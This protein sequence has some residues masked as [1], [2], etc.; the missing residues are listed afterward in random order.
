M[1]L[2]R[3]DEDGAKQFV[4]PDTDLFSDLLYESTM[5]RMEKTGEY[6]S[7]QIDS[8][9]RFQVVPDKTYL[10]RIRSE[11]KKFARIYSYPDDSGLIQEIR[12]YTMPFVLFAAPE[13]HEFV[14]NNGMGEISRNG[15][16]MLDMT[17]NN[18]AKRTTNQLLRQRANSVRFEREKVE[19][20][21]QEMEQ[22]DKPVRDKSNDYRN[23]SK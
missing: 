10:E 7:E 13:V 16:G 21:S 18:F 8:F 20:E 17:D 5:M 23:L 3:P 12:G 15:Y 1:V 14:F 4:S 2:L 6:T 9:F 11:E 19:D 22:D